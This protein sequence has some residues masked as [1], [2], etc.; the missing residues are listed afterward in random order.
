MIH[1]GREYELISVYDNP[2]PGDADAMASM[3]LY[4]RDDGFERAH[5]ARAKQSKL[6]SVT[7]R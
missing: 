5:A 6:S 4:F 7:T 1:H 3:F 2:G